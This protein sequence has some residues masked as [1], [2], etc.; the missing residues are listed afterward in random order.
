MTTLTANAL[1]TKRL[2]AVRGGGAEGVVTSVRRK[3]KHM[4]MTMERCNHFHECELEAAWA[5]TRQDLAAGRFHMDTVDEHL[6]RMA[7]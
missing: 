2:A 6:A 7:R 4:V 1:K 5:E 3:L